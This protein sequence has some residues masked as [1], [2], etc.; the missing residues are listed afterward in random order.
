MF[1]PPSEDV[2]TYCFIYNA[3]GFDDFVNVHRQPFLLA[4]SSRQSVGVQA[5]ANLVHSHVPLTSNY[6]GSRHQHNVGV[7]L[8]V[9]EEKG[10]GGEESCRVKYSE[11]V[12]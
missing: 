8:S 1:K 6:Y 9:V 12:S 3:K 5:M 11:N 10:S 2:L 7:S 4:F